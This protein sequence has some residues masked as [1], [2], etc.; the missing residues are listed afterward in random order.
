M[1][2]VCPIRGIVYR[3]DTRPLSVIGD[4]HWSSLRVSFHFLLEEANATGIFA[5]LRVRNMKWATKTS[6]WPRGRGSGRRPL[7]SPRGLRLRK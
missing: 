7:L 1:R 2:Q 5:G 3:G 6:T 4:P